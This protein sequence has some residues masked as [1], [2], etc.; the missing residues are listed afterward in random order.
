MLQQGGQVGGESV[1]VV[2]DDGLAGLAEPAAIVSDDP[3]AGLQ[4]DRDLPIPGP[5]AER[6]P[7]DQHDGL[8]R[9]M[10]LIVNLDVGGVLP[11]DC[12]FRHAN[13][14]LSERGP[15]PDSRVV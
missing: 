11:A 14:F 3:V 13:S 4:Q 12:D 9:A 6:I 2:A 5:A 15:H 10:V 8:A 7:M 1:V